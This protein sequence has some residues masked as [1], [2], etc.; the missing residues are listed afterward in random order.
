VVGGRRVRK[1]TKAH[2]DRCLAIDL[3][4]CAMIRQHMDA[5]CGKLADVGLEL[6]DGLRAVESRLGHAQGQ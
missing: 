3:V 2:Q 5:I 6:P 1:D 4:V